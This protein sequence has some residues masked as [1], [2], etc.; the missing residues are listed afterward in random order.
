MSRT[1]ILNSFSHS[2]VL[3]TIPAHPHSHFSPSLVPR[4][5]TARH[6]YIS[7]T[8]SIYLFFSPPTFYLHSHTWPYLSTSQHRSSPDKPTHT[9]PNIST[10]N[11]QDASQEEDRHHHRRRGRRGRRR[12]SLHS[13]AF[14]LPSS[15]S[16]NIYS[17]KFTWE[18]PNDTKL[19]LLT[20]GRY[21]KT[22]EYE[23]LA[24]AMG[25]SPNNALIR[26]RLTDVARRYLDRLHPQPH[27]C[28]TCQAA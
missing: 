14:I 18:G 4:I 11:H 8:L 27:L 26:L 20:Q 15:S 10:T 9:Y 1:R 3:L 16:T 23:N 19:L 17:Q 6:E 21:V 7:P 12:K 28:S 5:S 24:T 2:P 25:T 22:D 13:N